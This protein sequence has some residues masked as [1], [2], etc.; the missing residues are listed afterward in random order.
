MEKIDPD[1]Y[2]IMRGRQHMLL[3]CVEAEYDNL[4]REVVH[5]HGPYRILRRGSIQKLKM[6]YRRALAKDRYAL[7][8]TDV[9]AASTVEL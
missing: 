6:E 8:G 4:P 7:L 3:M 1:Q 9:R 5:A 2:I